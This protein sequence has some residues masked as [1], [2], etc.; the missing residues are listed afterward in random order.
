VNIRLHIE[1][2]EIEGF[3][4]ER[5]DRR[6]LQSAFRTELSRLLAGHGLLPELQRGGAVPQL[7]AGVLRVGARASA[8]E[9]GT[10]IARS[11][12]AGIGN[13]K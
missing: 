5:A 1:R 11:V 13:T 2:L 6:A 8:R 7:R 12:Y 9:L 4:L 10:G 3:G